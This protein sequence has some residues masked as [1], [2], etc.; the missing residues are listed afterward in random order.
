MR[1]KKGAVLLSAHH[2]RHDTMKKGPSVIRSLGFKYAERM[3]CQGTSFVIQIILARLLDPSDYGV[4]T[5]LA[6]FITISQVFVQ[7]G[8][9]TALIQADDVEEEDYS[10]VFWVS[11]AIAIFFYGLLY[12]GAPSIARFFNIPLLTRVLRVLA[13]ILIP[14]AL[15]SIQQARITREM[16]FK[17]LMWS[18]FAAALI[19]GAIGILFAYRG[20]GVWALV[21]Q[22]LSNHTAISLLLMLV[23]RWYPRFVFNLTRVRAFFAF[24]WKL[25]CSS[26]INALYQELQSFVI[27]KKHS[28]STLAFF[29]RGKQF[30]HLVVNN[31]NGSIQTVMLPVFSREQHN[32][33]RLKAM[34]RRSI[35][36]SCFVLFPVLTLLAAT[37]E[38]IVHILLTDKW[39]PCVPY[40]QIFCFVYA[41]YPIHTANLQAINAQGRS[42]WFL[43]LEIIKA[44]LGIGVLAASVFLFES[45]IAIAAGAAVSTMLS[46]LVNMYPNRFLLNYKLREQMRDLFPS[47]ACSLVM[48]SAV[49]LIRLAAFSPWVTLLLQLV[50][51]TVLYIGLAE[52]FKLEPYLYIKRKGRDLFAARSKRQLD[53][54]SAS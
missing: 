49:F 17:S 27:G 8:L 2:E 4:L 23:V 54:R 13:L 52:L 48:G 1:G 7:S 5:I 25:L 21:A 30:P 38:P 6:I 50:A 42:D 28:S 53:E 24:G 12:V 33:E 31:I 19:S 29:N 36:T 9:N 16:K 18:S 11:L 10:S 39:L 15:N 51:G 45:P 41:F 34:V 35:V 32:V 47:A 14:G 22:Q 37:A 44:F 26:L 20:F 43:R 46:G 3:L 40:L